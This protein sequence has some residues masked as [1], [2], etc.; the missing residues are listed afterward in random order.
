MTNPP[1]QSREKRL[2]ELRQLWTTP[3]GRGRVWRSFYAATGLPAGALPP[4]GTLVFQSILD[5]EYPDARPAAV[6]P[7]GALAGGPVRA[8]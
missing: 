2:Q 7:L 8:A 6:D 4:A 1:K 5:T 3:G